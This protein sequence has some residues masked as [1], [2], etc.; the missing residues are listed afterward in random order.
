[1]SFRF[2]LR[3]LA[4]CLLAVTMS[5]CSPPPADKTEAAPGPVATPKPEKTPLPDTR[6]VMLGTG[7]PNA[8]PTRSGPA[9]AV[10]ARGKVYLVDAGAGIVR[11]A[12]AAK[13]AG[14][15]ELLMPALSRVFM[16]HLHSDHT[17]GL[18]DLMFSPWVLERT[19]PLTVVGPPG[20]AAMVGHLSQAYAEDIDIRLHG[21]EPSNKTG[22]RAIA[23]EV[24]PGVVYRGDGITVTAFAVA[25]GNWKHAYGYTFETD[26]RR[27]VISGDTLP[28]NEVVAQCKGCDVLVHE[29]YSA[30]AFKNRPAEWQVYH[31]HFHTSTV[32]LAEIAKR[33]KPKLLVLYHQLYWGSTDADL[34]REIR[35]AGYEG[36]VVSASDLGVY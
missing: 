31:S 18:P 20:I 21:L 6:V 7:T 14:V 29:V 9:V 27:I 13:E 11:R 1:M 32:E 33:A 19:D 10:I 35:Q 30:E 28:S 17:I 16:T 12:A 24:L 8:D 22:Y 23:E 15:K 4:L 3:R 25:H 34:V 36:E 2:Q 5:A 26:E